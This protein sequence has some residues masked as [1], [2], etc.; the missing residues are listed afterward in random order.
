MKKNLLFFAL[1]PIL[2]GCNKTGTSS[3]TSTSKPA[4][5]STSQKQSSTSASSNISS[6]ANADD[7][8]FVLEAEFSPDLE[9][10]EDWPGFSCSQSGANV[11]VPDS[12]KTFAASNGFFVSYL[13]K[14]GASFG[15]TVKSSKAC[16]VTLSWRISA[17]FYNNQTY[18][19]TGNEVKVNDTM[20]VYPGITF[21][22]VPAT[23]DKKNKPFADFKLGKVDLVEG[24]NKI[25]YTT[26]N[27]NALGGTM[28]A[29]APIID[30]F[31]ITDF[32]D[33]KL[34]FTD[35]KTDYDVF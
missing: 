5:D 4:S 8:T 24:D 2:V 14:N 22:D 29:T 34:E 26:K 31:K 11:I 9:W 18:T 21:K 30:C 32:G 16:K 6:S 7:S 25:V 3:Q 20:V 13:Y 33:A 12:D 17:E 27:T 15:F 35:K 10:A 19:A 1:L 28:A 23:S